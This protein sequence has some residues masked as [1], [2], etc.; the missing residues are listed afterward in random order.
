M[1]CNHV[2]LISFILYFSFF[3]LKEKN[4]GRKCIYGKQLRKYLNFC[5]VILY[6]IS[7]NFISKF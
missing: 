6:L 4:E 2:N 5:I 1:K 7:R 3:I